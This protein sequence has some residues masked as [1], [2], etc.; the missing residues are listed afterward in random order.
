M[1][2]NTYDADVFLLQVGFATI[3]PDKLLVTLMD[4]FGLYSWFNGERNHPLY[5]T[6][7]TT[8]M[9]EELLNLLIVCA[10]EQAN[11]TGMAVEQRIRREII[12]NLCLGPVTFSE[13]I[14]RIPERLHEHAAFDQVLSQVGDY[15]APIGI[16]DAGSYRLKDECY[17]EVDPYF[18]HYSRNNREE[19]VAILKER[20]NKQ[21]DGNKFFVTPRVPQL[22][23]G[24]FS[25]LGDFLQSKVFTQMMAYALWNIRSGGSHKS[26]T[27]LDQALYLIMLALTD[28]NHRQPTNS[29]NERGGFYEFVCAHYF[30]FSEND[31]SEE[32][33]LL[34]ILFQL[35]DDEENY[36]EIHAQ[37]D[38]IFDR[39]EEHGPGRTRRATHTWRTGRMKESETKN[40][41]GDAA[42]EYQKK[43]Q[44]AL[45]RQKRIM[46]Q[47]A[48]AQSQFMEQN[49]GLYDEDE[50]DE[51]LNGANDASQHPVDDGTITRLCAYPTGTCIVCQEDVDEKSESYGMLGLIQTSDILRQSPSLH[52]AAVLSHICSMQGSL[53]VE[54]P[55]EQALPDDFDHIPGKPAQ[56][57]KTGLYASTC[58]HL[59]HIQCF[60]VYC[61][62]ID[63]RH[64]SQLTRNQPEN[65][66]RNEFMCPLCKSLG[67]ILLPIYWKGRKEEFPG[68]VQQH[69][70]SDYS[71][72]LQSQ[73]QSGADRI[74]QAVINRAQRRRTS[75][76]SKLKEALNTY[77]VPYLRT[78]QGESSSDDWLGFR[79]PIFSSDSASG[80]QQDATAA[81]TMDT[82]SFTETRWNVFDRDLLHGTTF[83]NYSTISQMYTRLFDVLSIIYRGLCNDETM[84]EMSSNVKS[85]DLLW[86]L[87]GY[88]ITSVEIAA[89][90]S[91]RPEALQ[92]DDTDTLFDQIPA[93]TRM[94]L[95]IL[96]DSVLGYTHVMCQQNGSSS[97]TGPTPNQVNSRVHLYALSRLRQIFPDVRLDDLVEMHGLSYDR[98]LLCDNPPLLQDDPFMILSEL[99][100]HGIRF[101]KMNTHAMIRVLLL[102]EITKT[103]V[104]IVQDQLK[105]MSENDEATTTTMTDS[106]DTTPA[107]PNVK[108]FCMFVMQHLNFSETE[109]N[110][111]FDLMDAAKFQ[112]LIQSFAL[113]F[114]R[115]TLILMIVRHGYIVNGRPPM[116]DANTNEFDRLLNLL[117]LPSLDELIQLD[118]D[119]QL[120]A[121]WCEQH[122][123]ESSRELQMH[124][125]AVAM[126]DTSAA[127]RLVDIALDTPTPL[128]LLPLPRR[129]ERLIDESM[130]R[131]CAKCGTIPTD[132]SICLLCGTFVCTQSF[133]CADGEYGECNLHSFE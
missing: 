63:S 4:R 131:I 31:Q 57:H 122:V 108:H 10:S 73:V 14:R 69:D 34:D 13:L 104:A 24:P 2:E 1:R 86:G 30:P 11:V 26:D 111:V 28:N 99:T 15:K 72:F 97:T 84:Q 74:K 101:T 6:T 51:I 117:C 43:K 88:T 127:G 27:N 8:F 65:R 87:V 49:E 44:A 16:N 129:F 39:L 17:N 55:D 132:P 19:A 47:F 112:A 20:W 50:D 79:G 48:Q 58:G 103:V 92:P 66:T 93:Q 18:Y 54:W 3:D 22:Q 78:V 119:S 110:R 5:D 100:F 12:H 85:I 76:G 52:D 36:K 59:M 102:A 114:L 113:P 124:Q 37:L 128:Y 115:R 77:V 53:D 42:S 64:S 95:R 56:L 62:S 21:H 81:A 83:D 121:A 116:E 106:D 46:A 118:L 133:C 98:M 75:G 123:S 89:R 82:T 105:S 41:N 130:R 33:S 61:T 96:C 71:S 29:T 45:E 67:N 109:A 38:W 70:D 91:K 9:V 35:R 80:G 120:V 60:E 25:F 68:V 94:L 7:Q 90:G 23:N 126:M 40:E 107:S 32:L 125:E